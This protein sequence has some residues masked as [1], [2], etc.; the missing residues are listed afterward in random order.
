MSDPASTSTDDKGKDGEVSSSCDSSTASAESDTSNVPPAMPVVEPTES[1]QDTVFE[2][3][4]TS[5]VVAEPTVSETFGTANSDPIERAELVSTC[6]SSSGSVEECDTNISTTCE[7]N[8]SLRNPERAEIAPNSSSAVSCVREP[9][10]LGQ[11]LRENEV[12]STSSADSTT[13][14]V[15]SSEQESSECQE[16]EISTTGDDSNPVSTSFVTPSSLALALSQCPRAGRAGVSNDLNVSTACQP[17]SADVSKSPMNAAQ[18]S[19]IS[20]TSTLERAGI[21][22]LSSAHDILPSTSR[23]TVGQSDS[24]SVAGVKLIRNLVDPVSSSRDVD[25]PVLQSKK[26]KENNIDTTSRVSSHNVAEHLGNNNSVLGVGIIEMDASTSNTNA[27]SGSAVPMCET[28]T[29]PKDDASISTSGVDSVDVQPSEMLSSS[30]VSAHCEVSTSVDK[31]KVP[32]ST[33]HVASREL[34]TSPSLPGDSAETREVPAPVIPAVVESSEAEHLAAPQLGSVTHSPDAD[35]NTADCQYNLGN[36]I[37]CSTNES[38]VSEN[39]ASQEKLPETSLFLG[40]PP[41]S[42]SGGLSP[43]SKSHSSDS[44]V[45]NGN[46]PLVA[47]IAPQEIARAN[48]DSEVVTTNLQSLN[49]TRQVHQSDSRSVAQGS[50]TECPTV[51]SV[52]EEATAG[53]STS[54]DLAVPLFAGLS[55]D[56]TASVPSPDCKVQSFEH[57]DNVPPNTCPEPKDGVMNV[58]DLDPL[59]LVKPGCEDMG[60]KKF[61]DI[62]SNQ[63]KALKTNNDSKAE[64]QTLET[65]DKSEES[66]SVEIGKKDTKVQ[67]VSDI[68]PGSSFGVEGVGAAEPQN[69]LI[70]EK[71]TQDSGSL[72]NKQEET[73]VVDCAAV[74]ANARL[75]TDEPS[76]KVEMTA[77]DLDMPGHP[78]REGSAVLS[79]SPRDEGNNST[80]FSN[81]IKPLTINLTDI[82]KLEKISVGSGATILLKDLLNT[83]GSTVEDSTCERK[84]SESQ[85]KIILSR[86]K[87]EVPTLSENKPLEIISPKLSKNSEKKSNQSHLE[88]KQPAKISQTTCQESKSDFS[89]LKEQISKKSVDKNISGQQTIDKS[90]LSAINV[91]EAESDVTNRSDIVCNKDVPQKEGVDVVE[92]TVES[93]CHKLTKDSPA[94]EFNS[95][96]NSQVCKN[97]LPSSMTGDFLSRNESGAEKS[98]KALE[99]A[100]ETHVCKDVG[101]SPSS[102]MTSNISLN[103]S[104]KGKLQTLVDSANDSQIVTASEVNGNESCK[105]KLVKT[106]KLD[107]LQ[108]HKSTALAGDISSSVEPC[109]ELSETASEVACDSNICKDINKSLSIAVEGITSS[110]K[111]GK[112]TQSTVLPLAES[113]T[114][115]GFKSTT[116]VTCNVTRNEPGTESKPACDSGVSEDLEIFSSGVISNISS[117][118]SSKENSLTAVEPTVDSQIHKEVDRSSSA[119]TSD[120]SACEEVGQDKPLEAGESQICKDVDKPPP[121]VTVDSLLSNESAKEKLLKL[122]RD[123]DPQKCGDNVKSQL[124]VNVTSSS[125]KLDKENMARVLEPPDVS[126]MRMDEDKSTSAQTGDVSSSIELCKGKPA[127]S[128]GNSQICKD[129]DKSLT[130]NISSSNE[131]NK[132][133]PVTASK[134]SSDSHN[135][136]N[137]DKN[138]SAVTSCNESVSALDTVGDSEIITDIKEAPSNVTSD[139]ISSSNKS[140]KERLSD[141]AGDSLKSNRS[142][143]VANES[144]AEKILKQQESVGGSHISK[145]DGKLTSCSQAV[146]RDEKTAEAKSVAAVSVSERQSPGTAEAMSSGENVSSEASLTPTNPEISEKTKKSL[147]TSGQ[148]ILD[149]NKD[150]AEDPSLTLSSDK[151][152]T[153]LSNPKEGKIVEKI[154]LKLKKDGADSFI[155]TQKKVKISSESTTDKTNLGE[156]ETHNPEKITLKIKKD[157]SKSSAFIVSS[158]EKP[159]D[160]PADCS[161][162]GPERIT[163]KLKKHSTKSEQFFLSSSPEALAE[164]VV[165]SKQ[166]GDRADSLSTGEEPALEK[167]TLKRMKDGSNSNVFIATPSKD[168]SGPDTSNKA[169]KPADLKASQHAD[170]VTDVRKD[171]KDVTLKSDG[172]TK[173]TSKIVSEETVPTPNSKLS[174]VSDPSVHDVKDK[175][176]KSASKKSENFECKLSLLPSTSEVKLKEEKCQKELK[177]KDGGKSATKGE[178]NVDSCELKSD[179]VSGTVE[180]LTKRL[181]EPASTPEK[182]VRKSVTLD[183]KCERVDEDTEKVDKSELGTKVDEIAE[184]QYAAPT[185]PPQVRHDKKEMN[186]KRKI[187]MTASSSLASKKL[188]DADKVTTSESTRVESGDVSSD[189]PPPASGSLQGSCST[190]DVTRPSSL[191]GSL[192]ATEVSSENVAVA[193]VD[194]LV[195]Q[196]SAESK[197]GASTVKAGESK[198]LIVEIVQEDKKSHADQAD[199]DAKLEVKTSAAD[200]GDTGAFGEKQRATK[201]GDP[202]TATKSSGRKAEC[203]EEKARVKGEESSCSEESKPGK[204][205]LTLRKSAA[206]SVKQPGGQKAGTVG[207]DVEAS[208]GDEDPEVMV[209]EEH[210]GGACDE[211]EL[212]IRKR[213]SDHNYTAG[214]APILKKYRPEEKHLLNIQTLLEGNTSVRL[215]KT[216]E[217][218]MFESV[219]GREYDMKRV[220]V[221]SEKFPGA[222][223]RIPSTSRFVPQQMRPQRKDAQKP[224]VED[225]LRQILSRMGTKVSSVFNNEVS[226]TLTAPKPS[227]K[228]GG[229]ASNLKFSDSCEIEVTPEVNIIGSEVDVITE[230]DD[231]NSQDVVI[232]E[233]K[234]LPKKQFDVVSTESF[235]SAFFKKSRGRVRKAELEG[236]LDTPVPASRQIMPAA[237]PSRPKRMCRGREEKTPS[238]PKAKKPRVA[239]TGR[240]R[241]KQF[242]DGTGQATGAPSLP[243]EVKQES[244]LKPSTMAALLKTVSIV[245]IKAPTASHPVVSMP[246]HSSSVAQFSSVAPSASQP[247]RAVT[248]VPGAKAPLRTFSRVPK[249]ASRSVPGAGA[250]TASAKSRGAATTTGLT[251]TATASPPV[252]AC[253]T[254]VATTDAQDVTAAALS[255][256]CATF[257]PAAGSETST[258]VATVP[259]ATAPSPEGLVAAGAVPGAPPAPPGSPC[260][261]PLAS[262][263]QVFEEETRMSAESNSR[264]QTPARSLP[265]AATGEA[266]GEESQGSVVSTATT[267]SVKNRKNR[268]E[269]P[270][271]SENIKEFTVDMLAE[272]LWPLEKGGE[273]LMIQEQISQYL[274]VK[275]FKRKY[276][277]IRRRAVEAEEKT[278]LREKGLVS[279]YLSDLGLTAVFSS[280]ILDIMFTDFQEKYEEYRRYMRDRQA[281]EFTSKQKAISAVTSGEKSKQD[282]KEKAVSSAAAW[283]SSFNRSR[284]DDRR[285]SFDLQNFAIHYPQNRRTNMTMKDLPKVGFY[286]LSLIPGQYTDYY[287][288]YTPAE[289]RYLPLNTVLYGPMKPN[290]Q[291]LKGSDGSQSDSDDSSSSDSSSCSSD[292]TQ[293]SDDSRSSAGE[294]EAPDAPGQ[295]PIKVEVEAGAEACKVCQGGRGRNKD[296]R[297]EILIHCGQCGSSS[298]PTCLDLTL[299]MVPH[300]QRYSWQ[301]T[302]CKTCIQCQDPADEDKMLFC[303]M[304]DR[305]YHIYCVGLRR[306]P[307]G[308]W[309]CK[310]CAVCGSCGARRPGGNDAEVPNA[311]WQ[312]EYKKGDKRTRVYAQTLCVPC[313]KLWRKGWYC[314]LCWRCYVNKPDEEVGLVNCSVCDKWMHTECC[315][316]IGG[317]EVDRGCSFL[318]E[319]CQEKGQARSTTIKVV[320]R[321]VVKV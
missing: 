14:S 190:A 192:V 248:S 270:M 182:S 220:K 177:I 44:L 129:V 315:S 201:A 40:Q 164:E 207:G 280:E 251:A 7:L 124:T 16:K 91:V 123:C 92:T 266:A 90:V 202:D 159:A 54:E 36:N 73:D 297:P 219:C 130:S 41:S 64:V 172:H 137:V 224:S 238:Q 181:Q 75:H 111:L 87:S 83:S 11:N 168:V 261:A 292:D 276:P 310:E 212:A 265:P 30:A 109:T 2:P 39:T 263:V 210:V 4:D 135:G 48:I 141:A 275:S 58:V 42:E 239:G 19:G 303:D 286:P 152:V 252:A 1:E 144:C 60:D 99:P 77:E 309:H 69:E 97:D 12:I 262:A 133:K 320:P 282:Y 254:T 300:L 284:K 317:K 245:K 108:S 127:Q 229:S 227:V 211:A 215:K 205:T 140:V 233:E 154:T 110:S 200:G 279:E 157:H 120:V 45:D 268:M 259:T 161:G 232:L 95:G 291:A 59:V 82:S 107:D 61:K 25:K 167:I 228:A 191:T 15:G 125:N 183:A 281:K 62:G 171:A 35:S 271:D 264:S 246:S 208:A 166:S 169:V 81:L 287:K 94:K 243:A 106:L 98:V 20:T 31:Q 131:S 204:I 244:G 145:A 68:K 299:D 56:P 9:S 174:V 242:D 313:S 237:T 78:R 230:G 198:P 189:G 119:M 283:N 38:P 79:N 149:T 103:D 165:S 206:W 247:V 250:R 290:E 10:L 116:A 70:E 105:E 114:S 188:K 57:K 146:K 142:G 231:S 18:N 319:I 96:N 66:I 185:K 214:S 27:T 8:T 249:A 272:Y 102:T 209:L 6:G 316:A 241:K 3:A 307:T 298:H 29:L 128:S 49:E 71:M 187:D 269:I 53:G 76:S 28:S 63:S 5:V 225:K 33:A 216:A 256:A 222:G 186:L 176:Q 43:D 101:S 234:I 173:V 321:S 295:P 217:K 314:Q 223:S 150:K 13:A 255:G 147:S 213:E 51:T 22:N 199:D 21:N 80:T 240:G 134:T 278:Y 175:L 306:V 112:E 218:R 113:Q 221:E 277:D 115:E 170:R 180:K 289:L 117:G 294:G 132:D 195:K 226:I 50:V 179:S 151:Q 47:D 158:S 301:C 118:E 93:S 273:H 153:G 65:E 86:L 23:N 143:D 74:K 67:A 184:M 196:K 104:G 121:T 88:S 194:T 126:N 162:S 302:D 257:A 274:G 52:R 26:S 203:V 55:S 100:S 46:L 163:L 89:S 85:P 285:C 178:V 293:D 34:S 267:E 139:I 296:G 311:Q 253:V 32:E 236:Q 122:Y 260:P 155:A 312:H 84:T 193:E 288:R 235:D 160:V 17:M 258:S 24:D 304:C 308:R 37:T 197:V 156:K 138:T 136:K 72:G 148:V 318:C 305:G